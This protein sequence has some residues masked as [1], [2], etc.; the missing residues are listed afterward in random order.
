[1]AT[2]ER[3]VSPGVFTNEVDQSFL[4]AAIGEIGG[5]V[6]GPT[7]KG[8][9]MI[10][11]VVGSMSDF[12]QIFGETFK[13]G[14]GR[15]TYLTSELAR[16]Y[17]KHGNKLTVIR[18]LDGTYT[19]AV[20]NVMTGSGAAYT[21][22]ADIGHLDST[23]SAISF[24]LHTHNQGEI[25]NNKDDTSGDETTATL[26]DIL[27]MA[28]PPADN[29]RFTVNV[30]AAI[31][32]A[33]TDITLRMVTGT[34]SSGTANE[35]QVQVHATTTTT[36]DRIVAAINGVD[37]SVVK[38]GS[39][40]G[41]VTN[42]I[43]GITAA[44]GS[45]GATDVT[46]T[47]VTA[48]IEGNDVVFTNEAGT[49]VNSS[50]A[51]LAGA[52]ADP[53]GTNNVLLEGTKD[54]VRWEISSVN[55]KKGTFT[56]AIRQGNDTIKRKQTLET[57]NNLSLDPNSNNYISKLIGD[58]KAT[59]TG[60]GTDAYISYTG[61]YPNK[62]AYVYV[63]DVLDTPDYLDENGNVRYATMNNGLHQSASLPGLGSGSYGGSFSGG[64]DGSIK[65]PQNFYENIDQQTQGF[66][67]LANWKGGAG[68]YQTA[69]DLLSNQDEYDVNLIMLPGICND[70]SNHSQIIAKAFDGC[71]NRGDCFVVA[72]PTRYGSGQAAS[73]TQAES[74]DSNYG[75][76][77]Y[78]W[79]QIPS[80]QLGRNIWVPP[81]AV[82]P[83]IYA[84]NDK[85]AHPWFAPAGLNRG[86][87]ETAVQAERKLTNSNR[88]DLYESNVNPI[89][90]FPGQ[91]VTVWGQKTLQKKAS[92][93]DRVNVR[94]LMIKLKKFIASS[95]RFLVFEQNN[96][97]TR[98][99]FLNLVN[100]F[101][102][103]VQSN[104]GLNAFKVVMDETNNTP[105]VVDRN[106]MYGQIFV[107]PTR[108]AEFIVLDFTVQPT[109]ATFPE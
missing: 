30:P 37:N 106:I 86:G 4:P 95:S 1:M 92:A 65:H 38:Y 85:V 19:P 24:K 3:V 44:E 34:A 108:T 25:Y 79:V 103:Q 87:I 48:G 11:T 2:K 73:I 55:P 46:I 42:G 78:P 15:Y 89:A 88:D 5:A 28:G 54:N 81:S 7:V 104:S 101:L 97:A 98:R 41:N 84:F 91:G 53:V 47:T 63:S 45:S 32:G 26:A 17:L 36:V 9:A 56:L 74:Y 69:L 52:T 68:E 43:L 21:G 31:G 14:S 29:D 100:P 94:R 64:S 75:A 71:E 22:S 33:G 99:R 80:N 66:H 12:D 49:M 27:T 109:G 67:I 61:E 18:I 83:G 62:S 6:I 77:Y 20:A 16:N 96:T 105:D 60:T 59:V 58:S 13:S 70:Q 39:G 93:L 51:K 107:Q 40:A 57:W 72:D 76:M 35:V 23:E 102:E 50:P 82:L 10:P 90:T 8:P